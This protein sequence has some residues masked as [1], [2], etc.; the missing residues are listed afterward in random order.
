MLKIRSLNVRGSYRGMVELGSREEGIDVYCLQ[1]VAVG[2]GEKFYSLDRYEVIGGTGGFIEKEEGSVVGVLVSEKWKDRYVVVE[3]SQWRIGL[4]LELGKGKEVDVWNVYLGQD[5][6]DR[7][8]RMEGRGNAVWVGDFNAWS[9][10]WDGESGRRNKEGKMVEDWIDEWGLK[11]G[12]KVGEYTRY[13]DKRGVG[14]VLDLA[15]YGGAVEMECEVE[16]RIVGLDH[17]PL[18]VE[19][20]MNRW[21]VEEEGWKKGRVDWNKYE[22]ELRVWKG[23]GLWLKEGRVTREHLEEVV[24]EVEK[25]LRE[26]LERCKGRRKW[27]SGRKRWWDSELEEKRKKVRYWEER[28][29]RER[30]KRVGMERKVERKE[31]RKMV[32]E[33]KA[34]YWLKFLEKMKRGE[35]FGF[36]KTDRDFMVDVPPIR[37]E[38][39]LMVK[40]DKDKGGEIVRGL[41]KREELKQEREGFWEEVK[42][43]EEEVGEMI[44]M[45]KDGKAAGINGLSGRVMKELWKL[46]WG[47]EVVKWVVEKSLGLGYVPR[48][49]REGIGVVM[50]KPNKEDYSLPSSYRVINLLDV[51]GK[52]LERVVVGRLNE[53]EK[54]GLGEEQWGGRKGR[55]SLE[56]I[57]SLMMEWERGGGLGWL[58]CMDVKGGYENVG[59]RKMDRRLE[60]LG[61]DEYLRKWVSSFLRER[62]SKVKIGS[63]LGE[64]V[65]LKGGTVQG[66]ALSPMLFM[67]LLGGV[68]EEMRKEEVEDVV[69]GV[70]VD[71]VDFMVVGKSEREIEERVRRMEVGLRRG[72]EKWKVDVQT[73]KLEGLWVDKEGGRMGK[74]LKWLGEEIKWKE[75]VRVLG[76]WWQGDGGWESHVA[77]RLRI[78]NMRWGLMRKLI[79]RGGRGVSVEVL[80]EIFKVVIKK[81]MMYGME[82][83]WDGQREMKERLQVWINRGLRGILGAVKTTPVDAMLGEVGMKRV[84]Y[85]LD[86]LVER[87]G[88]RLIRKSKSECF[89]KGWREEMKEVGSWRL[90][91]KGRLIRA[92]LKNR[93]EGEKWDMEVWRGGNMKW[94]V[95][96]GEGKKEVKREW[97]KNRKRY[98]GE[99]LVGISDA[100]KME[101]RVGIEG[102][103]WVYGN[104]YKSW[105]KGLG[106]GMTVMDGEMAGV[107]EILDE[108]RK[109]EGE[110][111][112]LRVGVD[113]V[114]VLKNLRKG[115]GM[116]GRWEQKVRE[117][118]ME[119][120]KKGWEIEWRWVPEHVGIRENEKV[121][122]LAKRGVHMGEGNEN[123]YMSWGYWEQRRKE[124]VE[125]VWKKYWK[126]KEKGRAYFGNGGGELG[127]KGRRRDSIFLFWMRTGHGGMR[128]T[129][130]GR[131]E[132]LC[133][134]GL[135]EDRDHVLLKCVKWEE[136][137]RVIWDE[138]DRR[139]KKGEW[140][141]MK[142]L[143]F[144]KE[145]VGAVIKFG[146]ETGWMEKR[147][148]ER[149]EWN[150]E[151]KEEWGRRWQE[152]VRGN[153]RER[154]GEKRE[155]N[156]RLGRERARR[157]RALL[158]S[159]GKEG[160]D[161]CREGTPIASVPPLGAYPGRRRKVLGELK[162]GGN[163][164][165]G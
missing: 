25:G 143:L 123:E 149:R 165:K 119:L 97:E 40:E 105:S 75:E 113:N 52:C 72:L 41:G 61:V 137:R 102:E 89:G 83:Y 15:I 92:T 69:C 132:G 81:A 29:K 6:H 157:R 34:R 163:R 108:V 159:K 13:D 129:R 79:G 162:D 46:D 127:H 28:W 122:K 48:Q 36:V 151:R 68:L 124:R 153:V 63:R 60:E 38:N 62:R 93:L 120:I 66:S 111:R 71:D 90:G 26:R 21:K 164:R 37:G 44:G 82:V 146:R 65:W 32:E 70:R 2:V 76:V 50:R 142:W 131:G 51:W 109:Y 152:G 87:W 54:E 145:G 18:E 144:S 98:M 42:V 24:E 33:K 126:G 88:I 73:M 128:G 161:K 47:K 57:A 135:R 118:G 55:S 14:R 58:L 117:W 101:N 148:G 100:S 155:R 94:R 49:F 107:A 77:N 10:R 136:Q 78:G 158:K 56:A 8:E 67:F 43:E 4:R 110:A 106:Y 114:G 134:C 31:Y 84:E 133:E 91:F 147:W 16:E 35:G 12:N 17:K 74:K 115:R 11:I 27:E 20:R 39:G 23:K 86:E 95:V 59:V 19:V 85:E 141:D 22:G 1:E 64:W 116:C 96:I 45:Q 112:V 140:M 53:W 7:L 138:W 121:D 156:L 5:K 30:E 125:R 99:G 103:L 160:K 154:K 130:Y 139:G 9:K 150:K 104:R 3:R 80:L